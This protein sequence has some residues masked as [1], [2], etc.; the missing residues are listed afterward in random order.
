MDKKVGNKDLETYMQY[1]EWAGETY[2]NAF[3][4]N[5]CFFS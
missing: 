2:E 4:L 3:A 1:A 5:N